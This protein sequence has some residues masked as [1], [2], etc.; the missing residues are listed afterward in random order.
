MGTTGQLTREN[1]SFSMPSDAPL[2]PPPPY[3]YPGATLL[4]VEFA[5]EAVSAARLLPAQA[6]L[7]DPPIAGFALADYPDSTLG[8]Y[9]EAIL[10]LHATF[11]G[12][13][14]QY[15]ARFYVTTD[16]AMAAGR[17]QA[18]IPKKIGAIRF[19]HPGPG[20]LAAGQVVG[21]SLERP[22]GTTVAAASA[23]L[24][25]RLNEP[26]PG[27]APTP[28][29]QTFTYLSLRLIPSPTAG[30]PPSLSELI[31]T[32]WAMRAGEIWEAGPDSPPSFAA[33][34]GGDSFAGVPI[35]DVKSLVVI[36]GDMTVAPN[37]A[38]LTW[39]F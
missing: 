16:V 13:P 27:A 18:G 33:G 36:R 15:A 29:D 24:L 9:R 7:A 2:Y 23:R 28:V 5:T 26:Q 34:S 19:D 20:P 31:E 35:L 12:A 6:E 32:R 4:V 1:L 38:D 10:Y 14:V 8:P 11:Q 22:A 17:E 37:A 21:G 25:R 30:R 39:T 3:H